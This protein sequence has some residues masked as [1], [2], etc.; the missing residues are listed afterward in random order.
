MRHPLKIVR[1]SGT[2][3][4]FTALDTRVRLF[5][6]SNWGRADQ[7]TSHDSNRVWGVLFCEQI[8]ESQAGFLY[9]CVLFS[10]FV[11]FLRSHSVGVP[12]LKSLGARFSLSILKVTMFQ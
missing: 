7:Q 10:I 12:R 5:L 1:A 9:A 3:A 2:G 11:T 4:P 6:S 8:S